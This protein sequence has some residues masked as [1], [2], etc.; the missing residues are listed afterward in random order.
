MSLSVSE[1]VQLRYGVV[2]ARD[3]PLL[4]AEVG[5]SNHALNVDDKQTRALTERDHRALHIILPENCP[6][7]VR[8]AWEGNVVALEEGPRVL[9]GIRRHGNHLRAALLELPDPVPQLREVPAAEGSPE[10]AQ[11]DQHHRR[12]AEAGEA[13]L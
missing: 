1:P 8:Q 6:V 5:V 9:Q 3:L 10:P 4:E 11:E 13:H 7:G 2:N 12:S